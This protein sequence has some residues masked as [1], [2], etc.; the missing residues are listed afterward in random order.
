MTEGADH[1]A[2]GL[3]NS[4][5]AAEFIDVSKR[6]GRVVACDR[7]NLALHRGQVHGILG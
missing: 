7:V 4:P 3:P 2:G 1:R 5:P 6:F